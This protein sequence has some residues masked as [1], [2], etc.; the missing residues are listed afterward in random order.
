[1]YNEGAHVKAYDPAAMENAHR[2][3]P[4]VELCKGPYQAATD[5]DALIVITEWNE[6]KQLD[7]T[8]LREVMRQP[9]LIDGR[10][11]YDAEEM[12]RL[13]FIYWGMGRGRPTSE[14]IGK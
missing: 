2:V 10:N 14:Q 3:L 11:I 7:K 1:M 9:Y 4:K 8:R 13:G 6:F 12:A 5:V